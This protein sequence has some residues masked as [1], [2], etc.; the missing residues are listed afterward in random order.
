MRLLG[1]NGAKG[2][3][4]RMI[5]CDD[6][7]T[8]HVRHWRNFGIV[9]NV[10]TLEC[11]PAPLF[12]SGSS[13]WCNRSLE[14]LAAG[15]HSFVSA[16]FYASPA[17]QMLLVDDMSWFDGERLSGFVDEAMG[18]LSGNGAIIS[19][20]LYLEKALTWRVNRMIDIAQ[21]S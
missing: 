16:Q 11:R 5:V 15:E 8:N 12:D 17:K 14:E 7:I 13:L 2:A 20:L 18:L 4:D 21:W 10:N 19:R 6:I 1:V 9:R 3:L